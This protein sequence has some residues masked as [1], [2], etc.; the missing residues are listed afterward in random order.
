M[1]LLQV[2]DFHHHMFLVFIWAS[3][4]LLPEFIQLISFV[5]C[6]GYQCGVH[7]DICGG[8]FVPVHMLKE[9][10]SWGVTGRVWGSW[11]CSYP[12]E[13]EA[14]LDHQEL[15]GRKLGREWVL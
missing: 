9:A 6:S 7:A 10:G 11:L 2:N 1:V 13:R 14:I 3:N 8:S 4:I 5:E 15:M 12:I